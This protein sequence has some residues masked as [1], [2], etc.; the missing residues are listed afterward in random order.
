M[1][2]PNPM[3]KPANIESVPQLSAEIFII[4]LEDNRY[5][6]YAPLRQAAF[7]A[8]ARQAALLAELKTG[9]YNKEL[10]TDSALM[11]LL[12][13]VKIVDSSPETPPITTATGTPLPTSIT[14]LL[15]TACNLR[16]SYC[17]ASAGEKP[18]K[19]M[20][21]ETAKRGI[22]FIAA[23]AAK[24]NFVAKF[25]GQPGVTEL[26]ITYHGGGE[27]TAHWTVLTESF[28]YARQK[29]ES[30]GI[31]AKGSMTSNGVMRAEKI[32]WIIQHF[33]TVTISY[34]GLPSIQDQQRFTAGGRGSSES[35]MHTLRRFDAAEFPY[36]LRL[37]GTETVIK[38]L[39]AAVAFIGEHFKPQRIHLEPA[40]SIGRGTQTPS[41]NAIL[42]ISQYRAARAIATQHGLTLDYA[43]ARLDKLGNHYCGITQDAFSLSADG[44]VS[45]CYNSFSED[46][47]LAEVFFYGKPDAQSQGYVFDSEALDKL[48]NWAVQH[49]DFC[50]DCFAKWHCAGDCYYNALNADEGKEFTG[51]ERCHITRE[52]TTDEILARI[53][54]SGGIFWH[55][56]ANE[57][58]ESTKP[59]HKKSA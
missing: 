33:E 11:A 6:I 21:L 1:D 47:K 25:V 49:Q 3:Q 30:M 16:C 45:A 13:R 10:E 24:K 48:R 27:P 9:R 31:R 34:D 57:I 8:N 44:N 59:A 5:L 7:F 43:A 41:A 37:T 17:Y 56:T 15:T 2:Y 20:Q 53:K 38:H 50:H 29:A 42:F 4:K 23:N 46:D 22:D 14:L 51:S 36:T 32:D 19:F 39:P 54:A 26:G 28:A 40:Y 18:A 35:V 12:R 58:E 52:L 55:E